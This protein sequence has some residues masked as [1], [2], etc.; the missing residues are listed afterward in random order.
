MRSVNNTLVYACLVTVLLGLSACDRDLDN[1]QKVS[2]DDNTQWATES[3]A[4]IFLNDVYDQLPDMYSQPENLDNF[5]DD[6]DAGFYYNSWK[7]KDGNLDP[8]STNYTLFG[9]GATGVQTVS[10]YNW[11]ALYTSIRKCNTFIQQVNAHKT[12]YGSAWFNKRIDEARFN[13]AFHYSILFLHWGGVPIILDPQVRAD[14][15]NLFVKRSTYAETLDFL[16]KTLDT[17]LNNKYL[18]VKYNK[19]NPDAGR[20]TLGAALM[21]KAYLQLVAA[22]PTYNAASYVGGADPNKIAGF[23][24]ADVSRWATAAGSFKKFIDDWGGGK[25]YGLFPEDSTLWQEENEYNAEVIWD[26]QHVANV[27][28]SNYEQYGG[29]VYVLGSYYTWGN[30]NPTQEL[31]DQFFM[32]N[33]KPITDPGSGYDPQRPYVGRERRFY[34]WIVYDGAPY[35]LDWMSAQDTI[36]TRI[37]KVRPSPNQ[38]DFASTD[39]SNTGYYFRKKLNPRNR[40]ATGLSGANYIYFRYAEVLLGY[41]EAQNEAVGP[42]ASVYSAMNAIRARVNLPDLPVG[43]SQSQMREAIRQERR[44]ELCFENK[45]FQDII[46][47]KIADQ[48]LTVD[49]HGMKIENTKADNSG[50][51]VYTPVGLNHPHAFKLRQYMHPIPQTALAQNAKLVQTPGY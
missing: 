7:Y 38:I 40:P 27:K 2:L 5:T 15:L 24:N 14:T 49:L 32:A 8:A 41:A 35:K 20:A 9:G 34:K 46:R 50:T 17:V 10:R 31:V 4:D 28:G 18:A 22:S 11:P 33:G 1:Q 30:Y 47:W 29:P 48:V 12:N 21:L 45:R 42:D 3:N 36:Y 26:R 44:I 37:D 39:V 43:L 19:G 13:R 23:G 25:T 51:W 6:N 16:T